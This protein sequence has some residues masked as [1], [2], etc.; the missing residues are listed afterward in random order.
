ML[1]S[2]FRN[3]FCFIY[4]RSLVWGSSLCN[5]PSSSV[6]YRSRQSIVNSFL[7]SVG[8]S[9]IP[10]SDSQIS[11]EFIILLKFHL[12][13]SENGRQILQQW[14]CRISERVLT[15]TPILTIAF[16]IVLLTSVDFISLRRIGYHYMLYSS[17]PTFHSILLNISS[18]L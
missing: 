7:R 3:I 5:V 2:D 17:L 4:F 8:S 11:H 13:K 16:W 10:Q 14:E 18:R 12:R 15:I 9:F 6:S 1:P